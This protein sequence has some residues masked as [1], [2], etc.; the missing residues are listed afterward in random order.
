MR[1]DILALI[2]KRIARINNMIDA[3][4]ERKV[5]DKYQCALSEMMVL[6]NEAFNLK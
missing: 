6:R 1:N 4:Q 5:K 2:D 3:S